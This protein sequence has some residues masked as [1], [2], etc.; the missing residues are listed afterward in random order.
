VEVYYTRPA[1]K[2]QLKASSAERYQP[3]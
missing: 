1:P 2:P 3:P